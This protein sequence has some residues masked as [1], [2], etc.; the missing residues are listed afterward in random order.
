MRS[1]GEVIAM[2]PSLVSAMS[3]GVQHSCADASDE[4]PSHLSVAF[5][6]PSKPY[7]LRWPAAHQERYSRNC[8]HSRGTGLKGMSLKLTRTLSLRQTRACYAAREPQSRMR[9]Q[10]RTGPHS[11]QETSRIG[12]AIGRAIEERR[13]QHRWSRT[14]LGR[15][16]GVR[17]TYILSIERGRIPSFL[18]LVRIASALKIPLSLLLNGINERVRPLLQCRSGEN[19]RAN[20]ARR[21]HEGVEVAP[22][23]RRRKAGRDNKG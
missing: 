3:F 12:Q 4:A 1:N 15:A 6:R 19:S 7:R 9:T 10:R 13:R 22:R 16:V 14:Q 8:G 23:L 17:A 18:T 2:M 11:P 21:P 5:T 20:T